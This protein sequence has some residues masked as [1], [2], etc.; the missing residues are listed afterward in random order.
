MTVRNFSIGSAN[1]G[2]AAYEQQ[3]EAGSALAAPVAAVS[4][5]R[6]ERSFSLG[7]F[8]LRYE[9]EVSVDFSAL[10]RAASA[11]LNRVRH[12]NFAESLHTESVRAELASVSLEGANAAQ[13]PA[14]DFSA[15]ALKGLTARAADALENLT[16]GADAQIRTPQLYLPF[17]GRPDQAAASNAAEASEPST[18]AARTREALMAYLAADRAGSGASRAG[19]LVS[20]VV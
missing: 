6:K 14:G 11:Q 10:A 2:L 12:F 5:G 1:S 7:P 18:T 19:R 16:Y 13:T 8:T 9:E 4:A 17:N 15:A 20:G 3:R